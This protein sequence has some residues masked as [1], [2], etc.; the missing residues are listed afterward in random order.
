MSQ[1][2][3]HKGSII[4]QEERQLIAEKVISDQIIPP[5]V[6]HPGLDLS[7]STTIVITRYRSC[8]PHLLWKSC[9]CGEL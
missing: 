4:L 6:S 8:C 2:G 1:G 9:N 7:R 5:G 3:F